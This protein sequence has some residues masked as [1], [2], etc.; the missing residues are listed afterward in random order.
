MA[1][2]VKGGFVMKYIAGMLI[3]LALLSGCGQL[4]KVPEKERMIRQVFEVQ[5]PKNE[6]YDRALDWCAKKLVNVNDDIVVKDRDKGKIIAKG[7]GKYSEYFDF[8]VDRQFSY[9]LTIEIKDQRYRVTFDNFIVYYDERQIRSSPME[10]R[11][12]I[13]KIRKK[14]N[15]LMDSL[16]E[17]VSRGVAGKEEKKE[18]EW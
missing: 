6:I 10:F 2:Q 7:T 11:T 3:G 5:L 1:H 17:Y 9:N 14:M 18:E 4:V 12:E 16:R 13:D 15:G 8:L